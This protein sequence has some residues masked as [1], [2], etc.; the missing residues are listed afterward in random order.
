MVKM[1]TTYI[2]TTCKPSST[3]IKTL[4]L[5]AISDHIVETSEAFKPKF[6]K[7]LPENQPTLLF[8]EKGLWLA[9]NANNQPMKMQA[10]W[11]AQQ[12]RVVH[13]GKKSELLLKAM[14]ITAGM[15]VIDATAG[16]GHD[17]IIMAG[18]GADVIMLETQPVIHALLVDA[19]YQIAHNA[20][21]QKLHARLSL[22]AVNAVDY[23][24]KTKTAD[25][26]YLDPMFPNDAYKTALVNKNMQILHHLAKPP[27]PAQEKSLLE[28]ALMAGHRVIVK[29]P[30]QAPFLAEKTPTNQWLGSV[31]RFDEYC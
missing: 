11:L 21:W 17:S 7:R 19:M 9:I 31:I 6:L 10:N 14:K 27:T 25:V 3:Q 29:R 2:S 30:T 23:L 20:N 8:D 18:R 1:L 24:Q 28:S 4:N 26:V 15:Q 5:S 12:K 13:A 22:Q 16:L